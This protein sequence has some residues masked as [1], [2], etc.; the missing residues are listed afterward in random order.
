MVGINGE[1]DV[2]ML[3]PAI[4]YTKN[5]VYKLTVNLV[6]KL[7]ALAYGLDQAGNAAIGLVRGEKFTWTVILKPKRR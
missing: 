3:S 4:L 7:T 6:Y 1:I 5:L 2:S